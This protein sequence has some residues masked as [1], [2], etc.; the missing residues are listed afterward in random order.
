MIRAGRRPSLLPAP[1]PILLLSLATA[2]CGVLFTAGCGSGRAGDSLRV[3]AAVSLTES[4]EAAAAAFERTT[5]RRVVLNFG[6]SNV[7]AQQVVEGARIDLFISADDPQM[8]RVVAQGLA[9]TPIV[10]LWGNRLVVVTPAGAPVPSP[11]P[12][13]LADPRVERI[14]IGDPAGVPAGVY[15]RQ[16]L[17][18]IG[19]WQE[20]ERKIVPSGSVRAALAAVAAGNA[21]A[22]V[23]YATDVGKRSGVAVAHEV[24]GEAAPR[25]VYSAVILTSSS[26][27][28]LAHELLVFL[29]DSE[30]ARQAVMRAGV[31]LPGRTGAS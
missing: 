16:W 29:R 19:L 25:I 18:A 17:E 21:E 7:L 26:Q 30:E 4:L 9:A 12:E 13:A 28:R 2:A 20:I 31:S 11:M 8:A 27:P 22:G 1:G 14:A 10:P 23:V 5:G 3:S 24:T 15:A 6:A